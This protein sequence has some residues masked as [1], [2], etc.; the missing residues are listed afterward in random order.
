MRAPR[1]VRT[2]A[3]VLFLALP[4]AAR[5]VE[6]TPDPE[7]VRDM[8]FVA[9]RTACL[10]CHAGEEG[11]RRLEDPGAACSSFCTTCHKEREKHHSVGTPIEG[12]K[13]P[14]LPLTRD[15]RTACFTC[16]DLKHPRWDRNPWK[17]Q[18][19]FDRLFGGES[20]YRTYYLAMPNGRGQLCRV[21]H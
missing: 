4:A 6:P 8:P 9:D 13:V 7:T 5:G 16:H 20:R 19:L 14:A 18:S 17:A 3:F 11:A 21:C 15:R 10:G 2:L 1:G 12:D